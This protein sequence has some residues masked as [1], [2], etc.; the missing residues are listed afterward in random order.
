[1]SAH[2]S[3]ISFP[4]MPRPKERGHRSAGSLA[5]GPVPGES[6]RDLLIETA[7]LA[8]RKGQ[9]TEA[10]LVCGMLVGL[11]VD[12][13]RLHATVA[14]VKLRSGDADGA[15]SWVER[16]VLLLAPDHDLAIAVRV[17]ALRALNRPGWQHQASSL[18]SVSSNP[19]VREL[20]R[21][22]L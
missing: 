6:I 13:A 10:V 19:L 4:A 21:G 3:S 22:V 16:E 2:L 17:N 1:M 7:L 14:L 8:V 18:L 11:G 5:K 9:D 15:L 12:H 20:A